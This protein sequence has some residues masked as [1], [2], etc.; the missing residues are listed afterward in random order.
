MVDKL[1]SIGR[2]RKPRRISIGT[3]RL[4]FVSEDI[5]HE[6]ATTRASPTFV[7]VCTHHGQ[8]CSA[9]WHTGDKSHVERS[10]VCRRRCI[11]LRSICLM[12][13][14]PCALIRHLHG[15]ATPKVPKT[16]AGIDTQWRIRVNWRPAEASSLMTGTA[17]AL[18]VSNEE[19]WMLLDSLS[20]TSWSRQSV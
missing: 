2:S 16:S 15:S 8:S 3:T 11:G 1:R 12:I 13:A 4:F 18:D 10:R 7:P 5:D 14:Q 9:A 19:F 17:I 20:E 6:L